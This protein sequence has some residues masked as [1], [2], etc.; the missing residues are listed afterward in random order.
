M[1]QSQ[2]YSVLYIDGSASN[3]LLGAGGFLKNEAG[4]FVACYFKFL[5]SRDAL[6]AEAWRSLSLLEDWKIRHIPSSANFCA[7]ALA[8]YG[9][10]SKAGL[11]VLQHLPQFISLSG[12][13]LRSLRIPQ[14]SN[15]PDPP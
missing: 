11:T 6:L 9:R 1:E 14:A 10:T 5:G 7:D 13:S 8:K 15:P 2:G 3:N 4:V 12:N